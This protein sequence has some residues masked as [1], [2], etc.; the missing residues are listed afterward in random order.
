MLSEKR[1]IQMTRM[2]LLYRKEGETIERF[3]QLDKKDYVSYR[4]TVTFFLGTLIYL[5]IYAAVVSLIFV[6]L[7]VNITDLTTSLLIF[8]GIVGY[9]VFLYICLLITH[10]RS[11]HRYDAGRRLADEMQKD[12]EVL[13]ELYEHDTLS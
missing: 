6:I 11:V 13:G 1:V 9:L 12:W 7:Q 5:G 3:D 2:E 10:F 4:G 8:G